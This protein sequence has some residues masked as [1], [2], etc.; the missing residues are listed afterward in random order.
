MSCFRFQLFGCTANVCLEF[1]IN[2]G[3]FP[4]LHSIPLFPYLKTSEE[5]T[6]KLNSFHP[7]MSPVNTH[8]IWK[9]L[10]L[11]EMYQVSSA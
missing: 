5:F 11:N 8:H 9:I 2:S 3:D 10:V 6:I 4:P 1:D 7:N